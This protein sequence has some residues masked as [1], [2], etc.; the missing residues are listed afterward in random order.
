MASGVLASLM[1]R[2]G[3]GGDEIP[4]PPIA[5]LDGVFGGAGDG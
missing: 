3:G 1:E 4:I 2:A 5:G